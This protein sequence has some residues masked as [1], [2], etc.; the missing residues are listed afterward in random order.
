MTKEE[1]KEEL[2]K[3]YVNQEIPLDCVDCEYR[4]IGTCSEY[5]SNLN[6]YTL[7]KIT[8]RQRVSNLIK[9]FNND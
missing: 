7:G 4:S 5:C 2:F 8:T 6:L 9:R 1:F 3:I